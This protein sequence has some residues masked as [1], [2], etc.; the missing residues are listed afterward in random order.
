[1]ISGHGCAV[2]ADQPG[3]SPARLLPLLV[4]GRL[5]GVGVAPTGAQVMLAW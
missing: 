5:V 2:A 3:S 1:L 4:Y